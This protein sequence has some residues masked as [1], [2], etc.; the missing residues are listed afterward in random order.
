MVFFH[1]KKKFSFLP[2]N[3]LFAYAL[4][5]GT[6]GV[7][8]KLNRLWRVKSKNR[9][10]CLLKYDIDGDGCDELIT[11]WQ[12]GKVDGRHLK[13]GE[14]LFKDNFQNTVAGLCEGDCR[15][16]GKNDLIVV[17]TT[18]EIKIFNPNAPKLM[19]VK[20][21]EPSFEQEAIRELLARKQ[22]LLLE[23]KNYE[24][25]VKYVNSGE[26]MM[27]E[28]T[29]GAIPAKTRLQT[30]IG[31]GLGMYYPKHTYPFLP[32]KQH[33]H[34]YPYYFFL[35]GMGKQIPHVDV[36][37]STNNDTIIRSIIVFAEGIFNGETHV[38]H[39]KLIDVSNKLSV[40]LYPPRDV[41][42]D[43]HIKALVG[44][45][46]SQQFHVFELTRQL[47]RFSMYS[48]MSNPPPPPPT[49][50]TSSSFVTFT[51]NERIQRVMLWINRNFLLPNPLDI[52]STSDLNLH[53]TSLRDE[54]E[55]F[56]LSMNQSG[57][58]K[59]QTDN[60]TLAGDL[61][62]SLGTYLNLTHLKSIANYPREEQNCVQLLEKLRDLESVKNKLNLDLGDKTNLI[63]NLLIR[64]EDARL[65]KDWKLM[66][67]YYDELNELNND[68]Q[69]CYEIR[70]SNYSDIVNT[71]KELNGIIQKSSR[72]RF[73]K[74]KTDPVTL[75]RNAIATNNAKTLIKAIRVGEA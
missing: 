35:K 30:S 28:S 20:K 55:F 73:G 61:I 2:G 29:F 37:L 16:T 11:G 50:V 60:M 13:T 63:R 44:Y 54:K 22:S 15:R 66:I 46:E 36:V 33:N 68:L 65:L 43:I 3:D 10:T 58:V 7:Y 17:S 45:P 67:R 9:P 8:E 18:G 49:D 26:T 5:N 42:I 1:T 74:H 39:P 32:F 6:V 19:E 4:D 23:L 53:M 48:M 70:S 24:C 40:S 12:G 27:D 25:N 41:P 51:L 52:N 34:H 59:I 62:Q 57:H 14:V 71:I 72:L 21:L 47:P 69:T 56:A 31:I 75:S 64:S 38:E